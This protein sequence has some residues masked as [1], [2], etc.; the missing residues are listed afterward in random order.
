MFLIFQLWIFINVYPKSCSWISVNF[1]AKNKRLKRIPGIT[2]IQIGF[3]HFFP[4]NIVFRRKQRRRGDHFILVQRLPFHG[5]KF[6]MRP[7]HFPV[8]FHREETMVNEIIDEELYKSATEGFLCSR[9]RRRR[10]SGDFSAARRT[11]HRIWRQEPKLAVFHYIGFVPGDCDRT[12][13]VSGSLELVLA[14]TFR[15]GQ[16]F[17]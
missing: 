4:R 3:L 2:K 17:R 7:R 9:Q 12:N 15:M 8:F 6:P 11:V 16:V 5:T 14:E 1:Q 13:H 10:R